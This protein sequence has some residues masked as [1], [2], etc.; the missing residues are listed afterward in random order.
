MLTEILKFVVFDA[1]TK[2]IKG[3]KFAII[4]LQFADD[5]G[6]VGEIP[7]LIKTYVWKKPRTHLHALREVIR[8]L[9]IQVGAVDWREGIDDVVSPP[10]MK[11]KARELSN[12]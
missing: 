7:E 9:P 6:N 3:N 2:R 8:A 4:T 1:A 10:R 12:E 5:N 11:S